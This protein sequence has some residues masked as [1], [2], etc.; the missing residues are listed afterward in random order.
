[1]IRIAI[2]SAEP[3]SVSG[4]AMLIPDPYQCVPIALRDDGPEITP[5]SDID[6]AII[7]AGNRCVE[8][9][10]AMTASVVTAHPTILCSTNQHD[11]QI[12]RAV[13]GGVF[14][15]LVKPFTQ[16]RLRRAVEAAA[17][18]AAASAAQL[19][20]ASS[21]GFVGESRAAR[22]VGYFIQQCTVDDS[23][24]LLTG[25]TGTGKE[26]V[27]RLVHGASSR[28]T[29]PF[30]A[31]NC[32]AVPETLFET[33]LFGSERGAF[34]DA[35]TR[36]G[37]FERAAGGTLFLDEIG[38]MSPANQVKLLRAIEDRE[39]TRVGG[40]LSR[41]VDCRIVCSTNRDLKNMTADDRFRKDLFFRIGVLIHTIAPLRN[42]ASDIPLLVHHCLTESGDS[43]RRFTP[44]A[45]QR[46]MTYPWPGNFREL[47]NVVHRSR[48]T[49][50]GRTIT[51]RDLQF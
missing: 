16:E 34:T 44:S 49:A 19:P 41:S 48:L 21:S 7:D 43:E 28:A 30:V 10:L 38:D 45:M 13:H 47:R 20:P 33:E 8:R 31:C 14:D 5:P 3:S 11:E 29:R 35:V 32:A 18:V 17:T 2:I 42:R 40:R 12:V 51:A 37:L 15:Y 46:L 9:T 6:V 4:F 50:R 24:V 22:Q 26:L 1:M 25:E 23:P 27:A 36:E 39:I